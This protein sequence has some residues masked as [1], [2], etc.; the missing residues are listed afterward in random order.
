MATTGADVIGVDWRVPLDVATKRVGNHPLQ[1]NLDPALLFAGQDVIA[2]ATRD[3]MRRG[4]S[5]PGHIFI[6]GHGVM[7]DMDPDALK[8]VVDLVH[9]EGTTIAKEAQ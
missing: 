6:L 1:G 4:A 8:F 5:A 2:E 7:P 3:V 9:A